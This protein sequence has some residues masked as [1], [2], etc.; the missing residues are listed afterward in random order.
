M[1]FPGMGYP[2]WSRD[3]RRLGAA[4]HPEK[5][6]PHTRT[7]SPPLLS[8][9]YNS[10]RQE[11]VPEGSPFL[12]AEQDTPCKCKTQHLH[13]GHVPQPLGYSTSRAPKIHP[14][15]CAHTAQILSQASPPSHQ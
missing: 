10:P 12:Q 6:M 14:R 3:V 2:R 15:P 9:T 4:G 13:K 7:S 11:L 5:A 8:S 1:L